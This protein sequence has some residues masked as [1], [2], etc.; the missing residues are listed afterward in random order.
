MQ[1][2]QD[3]TQHTSGTDSRQAKTV[4]RENR[5]GWQTRL[6]RA[7]AALDRKRAR[8]RKAARGDAV[9][10]HVREMLQELQRRLAAT[11]L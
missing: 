6:V 11:V 1:E 2:V 5:Q 8:E 9:R 7:A 3:D 4:T 10:N